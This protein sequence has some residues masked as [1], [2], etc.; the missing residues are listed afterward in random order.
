[1]TLKSHVGGNGAVESDYFLMA[2]IAVPGLVK[3]FIGGRSA[4]D[5]EVNPL[6]EP[7]QEVQ[8]LS[9]QLIFA[10][11]AEFARADAELWAELC[12]KAGLRH[13]LRLE[14]AQLHV[15]AL[16]SKLTDPRVRETSDSLIV[17]WILSCVEGNGMSEKAIP[18]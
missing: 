12:H 3:L 10:G 16:G 15:Y 5:P 1:M 2:N 14:W 11:G 18:K 4:T 9:P 7:T 6:Y 13:H 8:K 17:D